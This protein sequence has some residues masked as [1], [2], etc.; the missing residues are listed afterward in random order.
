MAQ[1]CAPV[2]AEGIFE[3]Q[4]PILLDLRFCGH[5]KAGAGTGMGEKETLSGREWSQKEGK[6]E[7]PISRHLW[8]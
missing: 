7:F 1:N 8:Q 6:R 2:L 3:S 4:P 5:L